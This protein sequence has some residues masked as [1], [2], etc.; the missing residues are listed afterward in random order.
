MK[1]ARNSEWYAFIELVV[2]KKYEHIDRKKRLNK[3]AE[4]AYCTQCKMKISIKTGDTKKVKKH[5]ETFHS[6]YLRK[7]EARVAAEKE[8]KLTIEASLYKRSDQTTLV[9]VSKEQ[10]AQADKLLALWIAT[11]MRPLATVDDVGFKFYVKYLTETLGNISIHVPGRTKIRDNIVDIAE[12]LRADLKEKIA[13]NCDYYAVTTD[14]WTSRTMQ[15]YVALTLH[16]LDRA[17]KPCNYTLEV[18]HFPGFHN[19]PA[20]AACLTKLFEHWGLEP[21]KCMKL[22]RDGASNGVAAADLLGISHMSCVAHSL[23]L[24][25]A[26]ALMKRKNNPSK[27]KK[28]QSAPVE[29]NFPLSPIQYPP[30]VRVGT[31]SSVSTIT[32]NSDSTTGENVV[33]PWQSDRA[34][35]ELAAFLMEWQKLEQLNALNSVRAIVQKFRRIVSYI[36]SSQKA[37]SQ[38]KIIQKRMIV[39]EEWKVSTTTLTVLMDCPTRWGSTRDML[40]RMVEVKKPLKAFLRYMRTPKGKSEFESAPDLDMPPPEEWFTIKCLLAILSP[41]AATSELLGG[42]GY[43]TLAIAFPCLRQIENT[44]KRTDLFDEEISHVA[45]RSFKDTVVKTMTT[46][47]Q[48]F[49]D[50]FVKRFGDLPKEFL[51]TS[52]LDPRLTSMEG[53]TPEE[54]EAAKRLLV[55]A[56]ISLALENNALMDDGGQSRSDAYV[57]HSGSI[58]SK[59][60]RIQ[61]MEAVFGK[62]K[63][64]DPAAIRAKVENR[65]QTRCTAEVYR[66]L[67]DVE[68]TQFDVDP[69]DWWRKQGGLYPYMAPL[70][71]KWL[72]CVATSVPS[73]RAFSTAGNI[74]SSKRGALE[75]S[76]VRDLIFIHENFVFPKK[77]DSSLMMPSSA[78]W[79]YP[80][81]TVD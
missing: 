48:A 61:Q 75:P 7:H 9:A 76:M 81:H 79:R 47:R 37:T 77:H 22:V 25:V 63:K 54:V 20:I 23:Q 65:L 10:Q 68:F 34:M 36:H 1:G 4:Y 38:F 39:A 56:T 60:C 43:P 51:W 41:I 12:E 70:A 31:G 80:G 64:A 14:I 8:A 42:Q 40:A 71:R 59:K 52:F 46:V 66:Y 26:G 19:G 29:V 15:G 11:S 67:D 17:Y 55:D 45:E 57:V 35:D 32:D 72:A 6:A 33:E 49:S 53:V 27:K 13:D 58:I 2:K 3:H 50:L 69:L 18:S 78:Q 44:L 24:V 5:L 30:M 16:F 62:Q 28:Q 74:V 21:A 73:E